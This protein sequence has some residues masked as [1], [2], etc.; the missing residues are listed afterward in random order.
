M[1][2]H[3]VQTLVWLVLGLAPG[4]GSDALSHRFLPLWEGWQGR[5]LGRAAPVF[6]PAPRVLA[7]VPSAGESTLMFNPSCSFPGEQGNEIPPS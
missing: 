2:G 6:S 5:D 4:A 3:A 7:L 1:V